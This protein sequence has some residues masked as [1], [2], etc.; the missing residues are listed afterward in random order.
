M[1][2]LRQEMWSASA[3]FA[4]PSCR[5]SDDVPGPASGIDT[6]A[7]PAGTKP[8]TV[9]T[10]DPLR[11]LP[12]PERF[13]S[14]S[15][16]AVMKLDR[17]IRYQADS[18]PNFGPQI[19]EVPGCERLKDCIQCGTC[20]GVCPLSIYM[21]YSPRQVMALTREGFK[22]EVLSSQ[23]IWLCASCYA[24]TVEC[25]RQIRIT[26]I[27]YE[28]KQRALRDR[29]YPRRLPTP[30]LAREFA[31]MVRRNGRITES[32]LVGLLYLKTNWIEAMGN[33]RLGL[34][35]LQ[36]GRFPMLPE[37][38]RQR[39]QLARMLSGD[40]ASEDRA[41]APPPPPPGSQPLSHPRPSE[42]A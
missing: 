33:W 30:V 31:G 17:T 5:R 12:S 22:K 1:L 34:G 9:S 19:M 16:P 15:F 6:I 28:L 3:L 23:T 26:D 14:D 11:R 18:D 32:Y 8:P 2:R 39:S 29:V 41:S 7:V 37:R 36:R 40:D 27:M 24:C 13:R 25:P 20:S 21:D 35:L 38:I 4:R 42:V 10:S